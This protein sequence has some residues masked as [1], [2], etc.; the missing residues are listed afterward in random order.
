MPY[1]LAVLA[2]EG[3]AWSPRE[4][5]LDDVGD[6]EDPEALADTLRDVAGGAAPALLLLERE[7]EWFGLVR[8][9]GDEDARVFV[10]DAAAAAGSPYAPALGLEPAADDADDTAGRPAGD[11]D[12]LTDL[13]TPEARL[14][15]L[16]V[17]EVPDPAEALMTVARSAG[18]DEVL[19]A[20]R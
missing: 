11:A 18:F 19:D 3:D 7:D 17:E 9:D 5:D 2:R 1:F 4:L 16:C 20:M 8:V 6:C 14:V 12:L 10:S 15:G 13:G